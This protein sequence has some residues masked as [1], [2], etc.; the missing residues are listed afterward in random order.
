MLRNPAV[1]AAAV[2]A[3][4]VG[5]AEVVASAGAP[6]ASMHRDW[7]SA[8]GALQSVRSPDVG[9]R[10]SFP[11]SSAKLVWMNRQ[12]AWSTSVW[13]LFA[14]RS[15]VPNR[16]RQQGQVSALNRRTP[17]K[18]LR[19]NPCPHGSS[20]GSTKIDWQMLQVRSSA[21]TWPNNSGSRGNIGRR[22][23][24]CELTVA[25]VNFPVLDP[26]ASFQT[27]FRWLGTRSPPAC[28]AFS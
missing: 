3:V 25:I 26:A 8:S 28:L 13:P 2:A 19:Q 23:Y 24:C 20:T 11:S 27:H 4:P 1:R 21:E 7:V 17:L 18:Q 12:R 15:Q 10:F 14:F 5:L 22:D 9:C 16:F 6:G